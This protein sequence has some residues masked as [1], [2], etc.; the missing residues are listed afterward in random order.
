MKIIL[1][2]NFDFL[3][4]TITVTINGTSHKLRINETKKI[5]VETTTEYTSV[6]IKMDNCSSSKQIPLKD[7]DVLKIRQ[8]MPGGFYA[9]GIPVGVL[10]AA[11]VILDKIPFVAFAIIYIIYFAPL[12]TIYFL[13]R[14]DYFNISIEA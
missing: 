6:V 8:K 12:F 3:F 4:R 1:K 9:I 5:K 11:L 10:A 7:G 14:K 2:R 13:L